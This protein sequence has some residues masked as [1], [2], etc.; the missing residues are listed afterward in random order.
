M[1]RSFVS[2]LGLFVTLFACLFLLHGDSDAQ[3]ISSP[4]GGTASGFANAKVF[5]P[6]VNGAICDG[7]ADDGPALK[8]LIRLEMGTT[9][10]AGP[11]GT[12][13]VAGRCKI[14]TSLGTI[15]FQ[16]ATVTQP[17]LRITGMTMPYR[18]GGAAIGYFKGSAE[19][20]FTADDTSTASID[21]RGQGQLEIDHLSISNSANCSTMVHTTGT[22]LNVH[23]MNFE[24]SAVGLAACNDVLVLGGTTA[25]Q[26]SGAFNDGFSGYGSMVDHIWMQKTRR[27]T[28]LGEFSNGSH[29]TNF[30]V[31]GASGSNVTTTFA[32]CTQ[33]NP[34]VCNVGAHTI[35]AA[36]TTNM[37]FLGFTGN[38][39]PING[40]HVVTSV[41]S[42]HV[43]IAIDASGFGAVTGSPAY[44]SGAAIDMGSIGAQGNHFSNGL[45]E[46]LSGY[47]YMVDC[48]AVCTRGNT[49]DHVDMWDIGPM[50]IGGYKML[51][52]YNHISE[53]HTDL[54]TA[55][56]IGTYPTTTWVDGV[57]TRSNIP[58]LA[59]LGVNVNI[60]GTPN[61]GGHGVY[62]DGGLGGF[63]PTTSSNFFWN[64]TNNCLSL[65]FSSCTSTLHVSRDDA[66]TNPTVE[67]DDTADNS[68]DKLS[69]EKCPNL[70]A[71]HNCQRLFGRGT[72]ASDAEY[73]TFNY[74]GAGSASNSM[75]YAW[76][77]TY[78]FHGM[79]SG[80]I[81][82]GPN[83][84]S[85]SGPV[86]CAGTLT[87]YDQT[88]STGD[89][90]INIRD[91]A[92]GKSRTC[93]GSN[94]GT[95]DACFSRNAAGVLEVN[96]GTAGTLRD[97]T[98]RNL[99]ATGGVQL[100]V[101][102]VSGLPTCNAGAQG[103]TVYASDARNAGEGAAAGTG[104]TVTCSGSGALWRI[105]G[106]ATAVTS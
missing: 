102:T 13:I 71:T 24:G 21:T 106:V 5:G 81:C 31:G 35:P 84:I 64:N 23:D 95:Y 20:Q 75:N 76:G 91:G 79:G 94:S 70:T 60:G 73:K 49:F 100:P 38:W 104:S 52:Q 65:G 19:L 6:G 85:G 8:A 45:I 92:A 30:Y 63:N 83:Q 101:F 37:Q 1:S 11:G 32:T 29:F 62:V 82:V 80:S 9:S 36:L 97:L 69:W 50:T 44:Y 56:N 78:T 57:W 66:G 15:P 17:A 68:F 28:L 22:T 55:A 2:R 87:F 47:A 86:G 40:S 16:T 42:T 54:Q 93:W 3:V 12:I 67:F 59:I 34:T 41:D 72:A 14:A 74:Q 103:V 43:S 61:S 33:A 27:F 4:G 51:G 90:T 7:V 89:T 10:V 88:A 39:T 25:T 26:N 77:S 18:P 96:N 46:V 53:G 99:I 48:E 98:L 105:P 58:S